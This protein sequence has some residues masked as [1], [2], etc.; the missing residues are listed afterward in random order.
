MN[1]QGDFDKITLQATQGP[2]KRRLLR[3]AL[4]LLGH[5]RR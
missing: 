4:A 1:H 2:L 5:A 3:P